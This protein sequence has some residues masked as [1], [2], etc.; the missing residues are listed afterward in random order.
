MNDVNYVDGESTLSSKIM[1]AMSYMGI[2]CMVP[3]IMH[4]NDPYVRFHARQGAILW[5]WE[6]VAIYTL[7]LPAIGK[8]FF[9]F[10]GF[11]CVT[12]SVIGIVAA[13]LGRAWKFPWIGDW[14][15]KL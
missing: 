1:A 8:F 13:L 11:F 15:E 12:L 10:S 6:V 9:K 5:V 14:A 4:R 7:M 2:L 3:L